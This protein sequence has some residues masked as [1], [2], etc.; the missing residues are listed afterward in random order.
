M[1][2]HKVALISALA[3]FSVVFAAGLAVAQEQDAENCKDHPLL[4]RMKNFVISSCES[5]FDAVD[6][7][8]AE[9]ETNTVEGQKT[10][11]DYDLPEGGATPSYLQIRRNYGNAIKN[12]GGAVLY[13]EGRYVSG[14]IVKNGRE[15][16]V[17]VE[18][19][20]DGNDYTLIIV[21]V[22]AMTQEVT[23]GEML[24]AL[25]KDG[26]IALYINFDTGKA[27]IKP[28]SETT[29]AQIVGLLTDN[30]DLKVGI[31]GHTDNVG[32]PAANKAL[33][34]ARAKS[35]MGAV[36]KGGVDAARLSAVGWGQEK[37]VADNRTED[38]RAKNRRVEI[39]KK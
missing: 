9:G 13:D 4:S 18:G 17:V 7:Y 5:R 3:L 11:I 39:V 21:E 31:E 30:P 19:F 26:F 36:V 14:K 15:A 20:N 23:A 37:P 22:E 29:V 6:V 35:V 25:N 8:V 24:N 10:K 34:E 27:D 2:Q 16:W 12:L 32:T 33:S 38:G 28:E 1:R